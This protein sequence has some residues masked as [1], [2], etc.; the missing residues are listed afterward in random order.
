MGDYISLDSECLR[1]FNQP[2]MQ[3]IVKTESS[4]NPFAIGVVHGHLDR[5]PRNKEEAIAT[6]LSLRDKG[7]NYSM[8]LAQVNQVNLGKYGL[9]HETVFDPCRNLQAGS[10]I[11]NECNDRAVKQFGQTN[12]AT[13]AALSCY[14]SGNFTRGQQREGNSPSYVEKVAGNMGMPAQAVKFI[15][16]PQAIHMTATKTPKTQAAP[17]QKAISTDGAANKEV[18]DIVSPSPA[19]WDVFRDF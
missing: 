10:L 11:F 2:I 15:P 5:Q 8:G 14:Y 9:T 13:N 16:A 1:H 19:S 4:F 7:F 17:G 18:N 6:A 3:A 12:L